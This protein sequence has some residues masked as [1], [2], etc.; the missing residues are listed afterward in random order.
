MRSRLLAA[1]ALL[2]SS[3]LARASAQATRGPAMKT[4]YD[5]LTDS[6]TRSFSAYAIVDTSF[7]PPDTFAVELV[8]RWKGRATTAPVAAV[9][10]GLGRGDVIGIIGDNRPDWVAAEI[11]THAIGGLSLGL[12]RDVLDEEG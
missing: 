4:E 7:T 11:A 6:T 8:Q 2:V 12:Y 5:E 1:L 9:E 10:L 3:A